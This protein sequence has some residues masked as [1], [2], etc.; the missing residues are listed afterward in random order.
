MTHPELVLQMAQYL[1]TAGIP[2][3]IAGSVC[4]SSWSMPRSTNDVDIVIEATFA[5]VEHFFSLLG[6][7]YYFSLDMAREGLAQESM[8]NI[9]DFA[10]GVKVD[11]IPRKSR[12]FDIE[13]FQR[14]IPRPLKGRAVPMASAEDVI[15]AKLEWNK[16]TPSERQIR[17]VQEVAKAQW[18]TLDVAYL[19]KWASELGVVAEL[20]EVLRIAEAGQERPKA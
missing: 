10:S 16:I 9:I 6:D 14:R 4:S 19:R 11:L 12:P 13:Q 15:L 18:P 2:F 1:D 20:E 7:R 17:D 8:F 5:Q 3:M